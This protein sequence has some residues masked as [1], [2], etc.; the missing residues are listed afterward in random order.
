M[1]RKQIKKIFGYH[2]ILDLYDCDPETVGDLKTCYSYLDRL[3]FILRVNKQSPPFIVFTKTGFNGWIPIVESGFSLYTN[4]SSSFIS[5]DVYSCKK[6]E[7]EDIR[8]FTYGIFK[9]KKVK[10]RYLLRGK[11]YIHP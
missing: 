1:S 2:F 8:K 7:T 5:I 11:E 6:F 10:E 4:I 9:P 3:P